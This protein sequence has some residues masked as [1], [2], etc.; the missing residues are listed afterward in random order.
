MAANSKREQIIVQVETD[1]N[2]IASINHVTRNAPSKTDLDSYA[3]T[4]FPVICILAGLP[5]PV[6]HEV[7]RRVA[8]KDLFVSNLTLSLYGYFQDNVSPDTTLSSLVDDL[9]TKLYADPTRGGLA[10][11]TRLKPEL[12]VDFWNPFYA[13]KIDAIVQ[14]SHSTGGI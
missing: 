10:L 4:Q 1:I 11:G 6:P 7:G 13:F 9:W 3:L 2:A 12:N 5:D 14:Y 8:G